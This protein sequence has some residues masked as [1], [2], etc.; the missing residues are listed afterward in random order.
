MQQELEQFREPFTTFSFLEQ[1]LHDTPKRMPG[2]IQRAID[3]VDEDSSCIVL[4]YGC[5]CNGVVG[6]HSSRAPLVIPRVDDCISLFLGSYQRYQQVF[7]Q[8]PG[9]YY[10]TGGWI[11]D[12]KDPLSTYHDYLQRW[13]V[14]TALWIVRETFK[15]YKRLILID[16]GVYDMEVYRRR[17]VDNAMF[18]GL[19]YDE[20]QGFP[21]FFKQISRGRF[22]DEFIRLKA[23]EVVTQTMF[24]AGR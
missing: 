18:L 23:G 17:A 3:E 20:I 1:A 15:N 12:A 8:E 4:G 7:W 9:T 14:N 22:N 6:L 16:T 11:K 19:Q 21:E 5:C 13:D 24:L 10:L 2:V